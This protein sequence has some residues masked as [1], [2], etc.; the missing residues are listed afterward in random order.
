V[1]GL[2]V[3][4]LVVGVLLTQVGVYSVQPIGALPQGATVIYW[5]HS[6]EPFFD[7]ADALSLRATGS[8]SLL[9]RLAALGHAPVDRIILRLPYLEAAYLAS[10]GGRDFS[11]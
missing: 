6:N 11:S 10:T 2:L 3:T 1:V 8:V 4:V 9:S 5:R 7:S